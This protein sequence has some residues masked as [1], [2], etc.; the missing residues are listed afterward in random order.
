MCVSAL[1]TGMHIYR[2]WSDP[3]TR[4]DICHFSLAAR[5]DFGIYAYNI[6]NKFVSIEIETAAATATTKQTALKKINQRL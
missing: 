2:K 4:E 6:W 5:L 1:Y 3:I